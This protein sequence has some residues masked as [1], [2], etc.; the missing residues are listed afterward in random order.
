MT[1]DEV[2]SLNPGR[3]R[4]SEIFRAGAS[5]RRPPVPTSWASLVGAAERA[6]SPDAWAYVAGWAGRES[7]AE[8]N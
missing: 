6:M 4:Q 3:A 2:R 8:A 5:G 7:T 1:D